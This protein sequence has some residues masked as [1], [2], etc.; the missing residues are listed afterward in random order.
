MALDD[1]AALDRLGGVGV[2][3]VDN[4]LLV[5]DKPAGL[6]T[7]S[8][9]AGDDNLVERARAFLQ[10]A[11]EKPGRAFV[12]L[13]HRLDR[14]VSGVV[15]LARTSKAAS[16]LSRAFAGRD[17]DKRYLAVVEGRAPEGEVRLVDRLGPR[18][19]GGRGVVRRPD[20]QE[21]T[22]SFRCLARDRRLSLLDV[23]L[24]TGRKHQIRAQLALA[25]LP[26]L[27]DPL[28]GTGLRDLGR[29]ALH[30]RRLTLIH[31]VRKEA[32][33]VVAPMAADL[34]ALMRRFG[35]ALSRSDV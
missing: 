1:P 8:A 13:V 26:V 34:D 22:L 11:L 4:H 28:Y 23:R 30:A 29:P 9:E 2:L 10:V 25:A 20:G 16:R 19:D 32:L 17:V 27:G 7:Q 6:L 24:L 18:P 12:G 15:V 21:A 35:T 3:Y 31:P 14:N 33:T 5:V